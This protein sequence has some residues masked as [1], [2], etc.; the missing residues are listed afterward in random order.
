MYRRYFVVW[1]SSWL[2]SFPIDDYG[3]EKFF[4]EENHNISEPV[5]DNVTY[6]LEYEID[7]DEEKISDYDWRNHIDKL[8]ELQS[9]VDDEDVKGKINE[10][11]YLKLMD[12]LKDLYKLCQ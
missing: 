11:E 7:T 8:K 4:R 10:G 6:E 5:D 12:G 3:N 9:I 2:C 1:R